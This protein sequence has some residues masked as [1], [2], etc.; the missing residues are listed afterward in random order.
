[1]AHY[2]VP[3]ILKSRLILNDGLSGESARGRFKERRKQ[4]KGLD[5][6]LIII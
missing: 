4:V 5:K 6:G 3:A 2:A 1:M